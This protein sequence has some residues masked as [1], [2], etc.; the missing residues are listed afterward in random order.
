MNLK[1]N[2]CE[3]VTRLELAQRR[4]QWRALVLAVLSLRILLSQ[5]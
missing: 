5:N 2:G 1:D 3:D 4:V